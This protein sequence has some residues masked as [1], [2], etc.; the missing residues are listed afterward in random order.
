VRWVW[1]NAYW[2]GVSFLWAAVH[3]LIL[4]QLVSERCAGPLRNSLYGLLTAV[5]LVVAM[6]ATPVSGMWS[7][8]T[9]SRWGRRRPWM[10]AGALLASLCLYGLVSAPGCLALGAWYIALQLCSNLAHGPGQ[11]LIPD[12]VPE[13]QRGIASGIKSFLDMLGVVAAALVM[14]RVLGGGS[15]AFVQAALVVIGVL[16]GSLAITLG[17]AHEPSAAPPPSA[18]RGSVWKRIASVYAID[19]VKHRRYGQLLASRFCVLLGVYAV[20]AFGYYF[21]EDAIAP[22]D[23]NAT[24]GRLMAVIGVSVMVASYPAGYLSER[25]G[26]RPLS[27]AACAAAALGMALLGQSHDVR[28]IVVLGAVIGMAMGAFNATNWAWATDLV[29]PEEAG[30]YLGLSNLAT[31]GS[32]AVARLVGPLIDVGNRWRPGAGYTLMFAVATLGALIA[33]V[34]TITLEG[35]RDSP[36]SRGSI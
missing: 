5:G 19:L 36:A 7:D 29:P 24:V 6:L 12:C 23:P 27:V 34:L 8:R 2:F 11:G 3:T 32:G 28:S 14:G 26:R 17:G 9:V 21:V 10:V 31:A 25:W 20:Q 33:L 22:P 30:R 16:L 15:R 13:N 18:R 4:P 1:L 35:G